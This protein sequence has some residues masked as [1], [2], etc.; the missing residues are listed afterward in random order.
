MALFKVITEDEKGNKILYKKPEDLIMLGSGG[1]DHLE[2]LR[3][4]H[5]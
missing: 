1:I 4:N 3:I 2:S 5:F